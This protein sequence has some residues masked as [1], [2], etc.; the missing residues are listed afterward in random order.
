MSVFPFVQ[1]YLQH[2]PIVD[3]YLRGDRTETMNQTSLM[4]MTLEMFAMVFLVAVALYI[5]SVVL[6]IVEWNKIP[7]W[8]KVVGILGLLSGCAIV[9]LIVVLV[10][11]KN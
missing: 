2:R 10:T 3:A 5:T 6:L 4:G 8:A 1:E 9:T 7:D 11:R